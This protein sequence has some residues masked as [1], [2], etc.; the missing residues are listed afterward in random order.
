MAEGKKQASVAS[1]LT[2][3]S[4]HSD[5]PSSVTMG[6]VPSVETSEASLLSDRFEAK[7][8]I[9]PSKA[10]A[11]PP[12]REIAR[13]LDENQ[14]LKEDIKRLKSKACCFDLCFKFC[15][16]KDSALLDDPSA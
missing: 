7:A 12:T 4:G 8:R 14:R 9:K 16:P 1:V 2:A 11:K 13:L 15:R 6:D 3:G 5:P 10:N